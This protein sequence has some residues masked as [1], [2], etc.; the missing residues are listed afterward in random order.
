MSKKK[1]MILLIEDDKESADEYLEDASTYLSIFDV[2]YE[3]PPRDIS[4]IVDLIKKYDAVA[5][6]V[7]ERL[8][9]HS[10][11]GYLGID[12][13][14][15]LKNAKRG[16][17]VA[18]LTE[19]E[20]DQIL[21]KVP[22]EQLFRKFDL[23]KDSVK[24][25]HFDILKD[26]IRLYQKKLDA[27]R[28]PKKKTSKDNKSIVKDIARS[29]F[30]IDEAIE[31]IVWFSSRKRKEL[32]LLE[33]SRTSLPTNSIEPFL[34]SASKELPVDLLVAD[35]SPKEWSDIQKGKIKLPS[36]WDLKNSTSFKRESFLSEE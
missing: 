24:K 16:L 28:M 11:A 2:K 18:I 35:V 4:G 25:Y 10:N 27:S 13:L 31:E 15:Y 32:Q 12:V 20:Q 14:N 1:Q 7:D 3:V 36:G 22:R 21:R 6:V 17:P 9:Q 34:I 8:R 26:L 5:V 30:S 19:Y 23:L 29:H 33:V